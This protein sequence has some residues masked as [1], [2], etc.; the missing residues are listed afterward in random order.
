MD[1]EHYLEKS[2]TDKACEKCNQHKAWCECQ[3]KEEFK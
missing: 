1:N 2:P 3:Q